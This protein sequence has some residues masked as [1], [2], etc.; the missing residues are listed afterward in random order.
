MRLIPSIAA[1]VLS[2]N[3]VI[4]SPRQRPNNRFTLKD[5]LSGHYIIANGRHK[6]LIIEGVLKNLFGRDK[7]HPSMIDSN[8]IYCDL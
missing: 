3:G 2:A 4:L 7:A 8:G 6:F 5:G 1:T